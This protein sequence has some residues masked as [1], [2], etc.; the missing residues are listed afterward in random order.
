[1]LRSLVGSEMCIRDSVSCIIPP[2]V[3]ASLTCNGRNRHARCHRCACS[4][5]GR[6]KTYTKRIYTRETRNESCHNQR[7]C[8]R[9]HA[10]LCRCRRYKSSVPP[11]P[12]LL[13]SFVTLHGSHVPS[14]IQSMQY[15]VSQTAQYSKQPSQFF[16]WQPSHSLRLSGGFSSEQELQNLSS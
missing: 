9:R 10:R 6:C 4:I 12:A 5:H 16:L 2:L 15:F 8:N 1:M 14:G 7:K 11:I 13:W 3:L